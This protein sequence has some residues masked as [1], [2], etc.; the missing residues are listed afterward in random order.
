L[1]QL[2]RYS[3]SLA[4][5][6]LSAASAYGAGAQLWNGAGWYVVADTSVGR[7]ILGSPMP[8]PKSCEAV[9]PPSDEDIVYICVD[10]Q[11]RPSWDE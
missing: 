6:L 10:L 9:R 7:F 4:A 5:A 1:G 8:D 3:A 11:V 2:I